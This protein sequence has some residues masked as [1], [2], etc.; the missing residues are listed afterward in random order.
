MLFALMILATAGVAAGQTVDYRFH[1]T[2]GPTVDEFG[3]PRAEAVGYEVYVR[4]DADPERR[5]ATVMGDTT[6]TLA[7]RAGVVHRIRVAAFD[8]RGRLSEKS[9]WSEPVYYED[10]SRGGTPT[11]PGAALDGNSPNPFN[12]TTSI[13]YGVPEGVTASTRMILEVYSLD[14]HRV[15]SFEIDRSPGWHEAIWNGTDDQGRPQATGMYVT[16]FVVGSD[17]VTGKMTMLK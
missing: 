15:R 6:W 12:P 9:E 13:R 5:V 11:P 8:D 10:D 1:W 2:P 3:M 4:E 14:G 17:V 16:R 7:A